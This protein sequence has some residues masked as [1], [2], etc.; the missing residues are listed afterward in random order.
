MYL[1]AIRRQQYVRARQLLDEVARVALGV[2]ND[3][4]KG[5]PDVS[6]SEPKLIRQLRT[7][8]VERTERAVRQGRLVSGHK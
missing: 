8:R 3:F 6:Q 1:E 2:V 7:R 4:R 5:P